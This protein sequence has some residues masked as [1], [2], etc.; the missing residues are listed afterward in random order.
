M[1]KEFRSYAMDSGVDEIKEL[2][3]YT[4]PGVAELIERELDSQG[5]NAG[6]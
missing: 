4:T 5:T 2:A 1:I 3:D 6:Q